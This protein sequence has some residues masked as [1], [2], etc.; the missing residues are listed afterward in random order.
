M[1]QVREKL[2]VEFLAALTKVDH[3]VQTK[4]TQALK[5]ETH[6]ERLLAKC[7]NDPAYNAQLAGLGIEV[8]P[9]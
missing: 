1:R 6:F 9:G 8:P 5:E 7:G 2:Y 4:R 3:M